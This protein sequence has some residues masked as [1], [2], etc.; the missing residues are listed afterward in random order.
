[1]RVTIGSCI[2]PAA[3]TICV[4][5]AAPLAFGEAPVDV[6]STTPDR[7]RVEGR[8]SAGS[9][10]VAAPG[11][12]VPT[13]N[14]PRETGSTTATGKTSIG[15]ST[16]SIGKSSQSIS[17]STPGKGIVGPRD[18][19]ALLECFTPGAFYNPTTDALVSAADR[20]QPDTPTNP[21]NPTSPTANTGP[22]APPP[23]PSRDQVETWARTAIATLQIPT[24]T[25]HIGPDPTANEWNMAI[26]GHPLWLWTDNPRTLNTTVTTNGITITITAHLKHLRYTMGDNTTLTCRTWTPYTTSVKPGTPSPTCGYTYTWPSLP[27]SDYTITATSHWTA[28]WTALGY[29]GTVPLQA[30]ANRNLPVGELHALVIR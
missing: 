11:K 22:A 19:P 16:Q 5:L 27:K 23:P 1:M 14:T 8:Q 3:M 30:T 17:G 7:M 6:T 25:P 9:A 29:T 18:T 10:E 28:Q 12:R 13:R 21:T 15:K 20:C 2:I 4:A 26:V 24:P